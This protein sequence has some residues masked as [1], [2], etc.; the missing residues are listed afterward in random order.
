MMQAVI[1]IAETKNF[2]L[3]GKELGLTSSAVH[4]RIQSANRLLGTRLVVGAE[5]GALLTESGEVFYSEAVRAV[6]QTLLTEERVIA[7]SALKAKRLQLGHSTCL[8]PRLL[9]LIYSPQFAS[10]L[11][12]RLEHKSGL[13]LALAEEVARG[14]LHAGLGYLPIQHPDLITYQ[15]AE[16]RVVVCVPTV[17]SLAVKPL[18]HPQDLDGEPIIATSRDAFP[19]LHQQIDDFFQNFGITLQ[20]VADA[21]GPSEAISMVEQNMGICL[22][23]QSSARSTVVTKPLFPRTLTRRCG[24]FV[25]GDNRQPELAAFIELLLKRSRN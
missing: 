11:G 9:G 3:A 25:R 12:M 5:D 6:A 7:A 24:L 18:I 20:I 16:E 1:A 23:A 21:F 15:L 19:V 14:I 2:M 22:L 13:T 10:G 4:K 17:H 8:P